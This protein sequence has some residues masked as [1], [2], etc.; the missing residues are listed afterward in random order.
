[1]GVNGLNSVQK[2]TI[3]KKKSKVGIDE[4][5][6]NYEGSCI[7]MIIGFVQ[8]QRSS[9]ELVLKKWIDIPS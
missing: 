8:Y 4:M 5:L 3:L 1:M 6:S 9:V 7:P 2:A